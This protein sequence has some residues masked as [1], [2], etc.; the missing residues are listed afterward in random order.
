MPDR[1]CLVPDATGDAGP[2]GPLICA[3]GAAIADLL[4]VDTACSTSTGQRDPAS[5]WRTLISANAARAAKRQTTRKPYVDLRRGAV[6]TWGLKQ[7]LGSPTVPEMEQ[8]GSPRRARHRHVFLIY[9]KNARTTPRADLI[10]RNKRF[11]VLS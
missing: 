2:C 10:L 7:R 11:M 9:V 8:L 3:C 5:R 6:A 4:D 1:N